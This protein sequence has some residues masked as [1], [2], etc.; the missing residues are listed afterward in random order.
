MRNVFPSDSIMSGSCGR[1]ARV[2]LS[3]GT[4]VIFPLFL[5]VGLPM[6]PKATAATPPTPG[7]VSALIPACA[8]LSRVLLSMARAGVLAVSR[9]TTRL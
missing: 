8:K 5:N 2:A 4:S 6:I 7:H 9:P 1:A 3:S